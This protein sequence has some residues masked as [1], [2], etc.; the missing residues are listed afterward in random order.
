[1]LQFRRLVIR[2]RRSALVQCHDNLPNRGWDDR[3][4]GFM[5][6]V[7]GMM[8]QLEK[9]PGNQ[10]AEHTSAH[11]PVDPFR[12]PGFETAILFEHVVESFDLPAQPERRVG[13]RSGPATPYT[14][15]GNGG[16]P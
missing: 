7:S 10:T 12:L 14:C 15:K 5:W 13:D 3:F 1:M 6:V 9:M 8:G 11:Q 4:T 16:W 2:V